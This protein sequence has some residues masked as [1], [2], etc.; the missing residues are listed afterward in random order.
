MLGMLP[1]DMARRGVKPQNHLLFN[2]AAPKQSIGY[3]GNNVSSQNENTI[4][5]SVASLPPLKMEEKG[6]ACQ[7]IA[8]LMEKTLSLCKP[9]ATNLACCSH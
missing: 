9:R 5:C 6:K 8:S 2:K 4:V 7:F 1:Q 3:S